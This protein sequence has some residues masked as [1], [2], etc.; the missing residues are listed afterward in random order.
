MRERL[1]TH[2]GEEDQSEAEEQGGYNLAF[3]LDF[4]AHS[5]L[6]R[7]ALRPLRSR[8]YVS[9]LLIRNLSV[10]ANWSLCFARIL[11]SVYEPKLNVVGIGMYVVFVIRKVFTLI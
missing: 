7:Q 6:H 8:S 9:I 11:T 4:R 3:S 10:F 5:L 2:N 1:T